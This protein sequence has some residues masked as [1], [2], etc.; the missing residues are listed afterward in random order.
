MLD[1]M[2]ATMALRVMVK[3]WELSPAMWHMVYKVNSAHDNV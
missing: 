2:I 1:G 3:A